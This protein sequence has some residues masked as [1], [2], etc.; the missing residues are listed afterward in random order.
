MDMVVIPFRH[1][2]ELEAERY[3]IEM[4]EVRRFNELKEQ[5]KNGWKRKSGKKRG[6]NCPLIWESA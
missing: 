2:E 3:R 4:E 5:E 1:L 6:P